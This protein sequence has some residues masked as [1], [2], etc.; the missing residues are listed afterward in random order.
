M[1]NT[2]SARSPAPPFVCVVIPHYND[3]EALT[4][5]V[6]RLRTQNYPRDRFEVIIA[7]NNSRCGLDAVR[8]IAPDATVLLATIQGA[9]PARNAGASIAKGDVLAFI[10]SDCLAEPGWLSCGV[11]GLRGYDFIGGQVRT[12]CRDPK[13]P[14]PVEAFEMV[15]AFDFKRYVEK[16]GFTGSGNMFV[17]RDVFDAVGPFRAQISEDMEWSFRAREKGFRLGYVES[18][19]VSHPGRYTWSELTQRWRRMTLETRLLE[20]ERGLRQI[21][22]WGRALLLPLSIVPHAARVLASPR[23]PSISSRVGALTV[24][25]GIRVWRM[26]EELRLSLFGID[27]ELNH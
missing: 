17:R 7:D 26:M 16:V 13:R 4:E 10:D 2:H 23:L 20:R 24:L 22:F 3:L 25:V 9:G 19:V 8:Q 27:S 5:C 15:F 21:H 11:E 14:T 6:N 1:E 18:A 12:T